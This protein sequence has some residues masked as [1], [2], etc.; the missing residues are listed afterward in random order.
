MSGHGS[1]KNSV[2]GYRTLFEASGTHHSN[3]GLQIIHKIYINVYFML[4]CDLNLI[5]A[6]RSVICPTP[7][8]AISESN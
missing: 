3:S 5:G 8:T 4:L 1:S 2:M 6:R 7:R